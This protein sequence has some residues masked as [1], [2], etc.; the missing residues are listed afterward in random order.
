MPRAI[1]RRREDSSTNS[2]H[3]SRNC[4]RLRKER[5]VFGA[6]GQSH[7]IAQVQ[8][9]DRA[10]Q[11]GVAMALVMTKGLAVGRD[12][13]DVR[14][15]RP[16]PPPAR[17]N[18]RARGRPR[19]RGRRKPRAK[20]R[21]RNERPRGSAI[22]P[23]N[24]RAGAAAPCPSPRNVPCS[25]ARM[26][27]FIPA[28]ATSRS[29]SRSAAHSGSHI[30]SGRRLKRATKSSTPQAICNARSRARSSGRIEWL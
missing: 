22:L 15:A 23:P 7:V 28:A 10:S 13:H 17:S 1:A 20:D 21:G 6:I 30:P 14:R 12:H 19:G 8:R 29:V 25:G 4:R 5:Q 11:F 9:V 24:E 2:A 16:A 26:I 3:R 27:N 18:S